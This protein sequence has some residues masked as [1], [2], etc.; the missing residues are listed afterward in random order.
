MYMKKPNYETMGVGGQD[1]VPQI[2]LPA[3]KIENHGGSAEHVD[4]KTAAKAVEQVSTGLPEPV[5]GSSAQSSQST[6]Q[7]SNLTTSVGVPPAIADDND[8]IEKEWVA[9]AKQIV[10]GTKNDPHLQSVEMNRY[11]ATY[12][13]KRFNKDVKVAEM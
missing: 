3:L 11:K 13:K 7:A 6:P 2:E 1:T 5:V 9:K 4:E 8:L 10:N 12:I